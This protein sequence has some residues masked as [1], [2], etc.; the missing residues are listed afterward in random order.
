MMRVSNPLIGDPQLL[1]MPAPRALVWS[2][3]ICFPLNR[4]N[5]DPERSGLDN[6]ARLR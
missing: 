2:A 5:T 4:F 3:I 6:A 1:L